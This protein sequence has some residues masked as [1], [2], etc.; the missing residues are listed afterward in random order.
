MLGS[1]AVKG[2]NK[3]ESVEEMLSADPEFN[4][5]LKKKKGDEAE[6]LDWLYSLD[7]QKVTVII[8]QHMKRY[9]HE[10]EVAE[11][12]VE[13]WQ[14]F[15]RTAVD[16]KPIM[17]SGGCKTIVEALKTFKKEESVVWRACACIYEMCK[18]ELLCSELG[19]SG[20]IPHMVEAYNFFDG[21]HDM[22]QQ[23]SR[24]GRIEIWS[25]ANFPSSSGRPYGLWTHWRRTKLMSIALGKMPSYRCYTNF[26]ISSRSSAV[27]KIT[28]IGRKGKPMI[29]KSTQSSHP[30]V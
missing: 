29:P 26:C 22:Q 19:K 18:H 25:L 1:T 30:Y 3:Q 14:E 28:H 12:G 15:A 6:M 10:K 27:K 11:C 5:N 13:C 23:V 7:Y 24:G 9:A 4:E 21:Q 2:K 17:T 8:V 16:V 20:I